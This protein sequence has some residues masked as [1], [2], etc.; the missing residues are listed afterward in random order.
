MYPANTHPANRS[1]ILT[2]YSEALHKA[3]PYEYKQ[4]QSKQWKSSEDSTKLILKKI[5]HMNHKAPHH[6]I[7]YKLIK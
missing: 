4:F 1:Y 5:W 3:V 6:H 7:K 2:G